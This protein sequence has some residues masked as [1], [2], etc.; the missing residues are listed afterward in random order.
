MSR[1][2]IFKSVVLLSFIF[3]STI[4]YGQKSPDNFPVDPILFL[5]DP[6]RGAEGIAFNGQGYLFVT[7]DRGLW[8]VGADGTVEKVAEL[9]SNLGIAGIGEKD[10]LVADFG[11]TNAFRHDKND[12][13]IIWQITPEGEKTKLATGMGDP[14][15]I[16]VRKDNSFLVSDDATN[17]IFS[18]TPDGE[19]KLFTT[20]VNHPNGMAFN[21]DETIL[22]VAQI[23]TNIRPV[24]YTNEV[25]SIKLSEGKPRT[26]AD[27][28]VRTGPNAANDGLAMDKLG[29]LY[30][31]ANKEGRIWRYDPE[32]DE[33][34]IIA[35]EMEG[36]A[37]LAFGKGEFDHQSIYATTTFAGGGKI[38]RIKVG[39]EGAVLNR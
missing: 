30:I 32:I 11:P 16:L 14:N 38:W 15:F 27:L 8:R 3:L 2:I 33:M 25:W 10:L 28:L 35:K 26:D 31:A 17:E 5:D 13:G 24:V 7:A 9:Y 23:F 21:E 4:C 22:Y 20:A 34:V 29:R 39:V 1:K 18:V 6:F 19:V 36:I 12:D 37:S